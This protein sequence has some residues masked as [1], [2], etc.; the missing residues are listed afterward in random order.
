MNKSTASPRILLLVLSF[1]TLLSAAQAQDEKLKFGKPSM[2]DLKMT[3][4][5]Y[6]TSAEAVILSDIGS[7]W[8]DYDKDKGFVMHF[9]RFER[10]KILTK[11]G[12][13][14]PTKAFAS[15]GQMRIMK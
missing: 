15:T 13:H 12:Y 6:D 3:R 14:G 1:L 9:D 4:Y 5:D 7:T 8:F 2:A 11:D 10:I